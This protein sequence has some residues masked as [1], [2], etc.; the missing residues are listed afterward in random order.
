[1]TAN[2]PE[3]RRFSHVYLDRGEP[4]DI[5]E[6]VRVRLRS[7]IVS[8]PNL[9]TSTLVEDELGVEFTSWGAFFSKAATRDVLDLITVAYRRLAGVQY[10]AQT[11]CEQWLKG[12]QKIFLEE[13][14][15]Y[16]V[17]R[18]GGV[19][20]Y[21]NEE[22]ARVTVAAVSIL[23]KSRYANSLDAYT[24][25]LAALSMSPPDGKGAIRG[26]FTAIEGLFAL[27]FSD[28]RRLAAGEVSRLRPLLQETYS[29]DRRA[30]EAG[31]KNVAIFSRLD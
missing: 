2:I 30:Q 21:I 26:T 25:S 3:G 23:Q 16:R 10:L 18:R 29:G 31:E 8:I 19:H 5:N 14:V 7:L 4:T 17:D 9:R 24:A 15:H 1:V 6:R 20:F 28:V 11:L 13:N 27:M 12:V 22:F